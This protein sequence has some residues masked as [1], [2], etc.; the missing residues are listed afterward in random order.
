L[1]ARSRH[2]FDFIRNRNEALFGAS[3]AGRSLA[4]GGAAAL[5]G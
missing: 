1:L 3:A 4:P 2:Y 5:Y